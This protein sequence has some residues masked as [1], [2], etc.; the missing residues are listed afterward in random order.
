MPT[1]LS[2]THRFWY[3]CIALASTFATKSM[4][5]PLV[6]LMAHSLGASAV[7]VGAV[8]SAAFVLPLFLAIPIGVLI[9][10]WGTRPALL[11]GSI[12]TV[13]APTGI[14]L[15]PTLPYLVLV[16]VAVGL[17]NIL[18]IVSAQ[19]MVSTFGHGK[20]REQNFG[21]YSTFQSAGQL[22]GPAL[23]GVVADRIGHGA[24]FAIAGGLSLVAIAL[25]PFVG[26]LIGD[27]QVRFSRPYGRRHQYAE[28]LSSNSVR[29][30]M[31]VSTGVVFAVVM[32]EGFLPVYLTS[33]EYSATFIGALFSLVALAQILVRPAMTSII[34]LARSR[35]GAL[36]ATFGLVICALALLAG[37][38]SAA[39]L[40]AMCLVFGAGS[41]ITQPLTILL[42]T[43]AVSERSRGFALGLRLT[44][45]RLAQVLLPSGFGLIAV[46]V[47]YSFMFAVVSAF[48]FCLGLLAHT[49]RPVTDLAEAN[50]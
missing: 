44:A 34:S 23:G 10:K 8:V 40:I 21:W 14:L 36:L 4:L 29:M 22:L 41:G 45:N 31:T 5:A 13:L 3:L 46:T 37:A 1:Q 19:K 50:T 48:L 15:W 17:A 39:T 35:S 11:L 27:N 12:M 33:L 26:T 20:Q 16:Q 47:G 24:A 9:D 28:A 18:L 38:T 2:D 7:V 43:D 42:V 32:F 6:P 30:A 25:V 49:W